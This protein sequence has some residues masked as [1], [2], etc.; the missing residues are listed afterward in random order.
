MPKKGENIYKRKDGRWEGRYQTGLDEYGKVKLGYIYG[1]TYK[2]VKQKLYT[3]KTTFNTLEK[4]KTYSFILFND[5]AMQWLQHHKVK[6]KQSTYVKYNTIIERHILPFFV[7]YA[8]F[9]VNSFTVEEFSKYLLEKLS[10]KTVKDILSVVSL[11]LKYAM[12][13]YP[14]I[15]KPVRITIPKQEHST[16]KILSNLE[17]CKFEKY[18]LKELD[19]PKLGVLLCLYTGIRIGEL[20]ALVCGDISFDDK[21]LYVCKTMQRLGKLEEKGTEILVTTPKSKCS[22][23]IIPL[24]NFIIENLKRFDSEKSTYFLTGTSAYV[25]PRIMQKKFKQYL[26]ASDVATINFH[27]L[28]HTFATRCI[29]LGFEIKSLSEILGHSSVNITLGR[30]VHSS[31]ELKRKNMNLLSLTVNH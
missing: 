19:R 1:Q 8:L 12:E 23:R 5:F 6:I 3:A 9:A 11:I 2:E 13:L 21:N 15:I 18:L 28:R 10:S 24:P 26:K 17:Q 30:Y 16:V 14:E 27:V 20:C 7:K 31:I 25:E 4:R 22:I 29:E